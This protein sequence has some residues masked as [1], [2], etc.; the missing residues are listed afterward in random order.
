[1]AEEASAGPD[2]I[3]LVVLTGMTDDHAESRQSA[4][5]AVRPLG[6]LSVLDTPCTEL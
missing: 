2:D 1:M 3:P 5:T 6:E 4:G